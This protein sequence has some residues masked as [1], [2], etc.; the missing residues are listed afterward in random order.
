MKITQ[1]TPDETQLE[2]DSKGARRASLFFM[3]IALGMMVSVNDC[4]SWQR[5]DRL[6]PASRTATS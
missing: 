1:L 5:Y 4:H 3:A 6:L 2:I